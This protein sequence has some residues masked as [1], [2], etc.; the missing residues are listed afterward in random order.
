MLEATE[1]YSEELGLPLRLRVGV[2]SG[3]IVAG[4]IGRKRFSYDLWGDTVNV[5]SRMESQGLEGRVQLG[6]ATWRL[7]KDE[8]PCEERGEIEVKGKGLMRTYLVAHAPH[9]PAVPTSPTRVAV[10]Q[11][12]S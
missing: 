8:I 10:G 12:A 6:E 9:Q 5:A 4:V 11:A 2:N 7:V 3:P 1:Q